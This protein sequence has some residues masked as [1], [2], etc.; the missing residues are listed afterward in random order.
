MFKLPINYLFNQNLNDTKAF[1]DMF[2]ALEIAIEIPNGV[3]LD[4]LDEE[5]II[6]L[7]QLMKT[8]S[9][10]IESGDKYVNDEII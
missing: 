3:R 6:K 5:A 2:L 8:L 10:S 9:V 1:L 4:L 7:A